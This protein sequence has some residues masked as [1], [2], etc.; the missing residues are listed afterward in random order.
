VAELISQ[1]VQTTA[2]HGYEQIERM[3]AEVVAGPGKIRVRP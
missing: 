3:D 1:R 2:Y